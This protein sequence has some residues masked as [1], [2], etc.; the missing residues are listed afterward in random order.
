MAVAMVK[1]MATF[2]RRLAVVF[3]VLK[4][5]SSFTIHLHTED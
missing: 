5:G 2:Q 1:A 4:T 3:A